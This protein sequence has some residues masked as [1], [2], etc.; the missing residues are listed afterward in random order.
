MQHKIRGEDSLELHDEEDWETK[1][2][3]SRRTGTF[4][5]VQTREVLEGKSALSV[6][7]G[8]WE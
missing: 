6:R 2:A 1:S 7:S 4:T 3:T 8:V 5:N